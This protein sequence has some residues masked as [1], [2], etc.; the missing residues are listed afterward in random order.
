MNPTR[1]SDPRTSILA[2]PGDRPYDPNRLHG[3][4]NTPA[5][6]QGGSGELLLDD[7]L[8]AESGARTAAA[9]ESEQKARAND[10]RLG[11]LRKNLAEFGSRMTAPGVTDPRTD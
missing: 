5:D 8:R 2:V 9:R 6:A 7:A 4:V 1:A 10:E 11:R 3:L